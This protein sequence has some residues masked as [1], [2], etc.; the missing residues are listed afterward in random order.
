[1]LVEREI[2][3]S[4]SWQAAKRLAQENNKIFNQLRNFRPSEVL[5]FFDGR[6]RWVMRFHESRGSRV[7]AKFQETNLTHFLL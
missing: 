7:M 6:F 1:M 3:D 5:S 4:V 2:L